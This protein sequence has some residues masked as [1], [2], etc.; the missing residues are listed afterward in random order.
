[1]IDH[2]MRNFALFFIAILISPKLFCQM[3]EV[4]KSEILDYVRANPKVLKV[5]K[6]ETGVGVEDDKG[7]TIIPS[8]FY[9]VSI[10]SATSKFKEPKFLVS[11]KCEKDFNI[12]SLDNTPIFSSDQYAIVQAAPGYLIVTPPAKDTSFIL[13]YHGD[14]IDHL[15]K[16]MIQ[17]VIVPK[18][19][20]KNKGYYVLGKNRNGGYHLALISDELEFIKPLSDHVIKV[21]EHGIIV[22]NNSGN[23]GTLYDLNMKEI[24]SSEIAIPKYVFE[25]TFIYSNQTNYTSGIMNFKGDTL[26]TSELMR[27][28][29]KDVRQDVIKYTTHF[30]YK[31]GAVSSEGKEI[32]PAGDAYISWITSEG[33]L[34]LQYFDKKK[35]EKTIYDLTKR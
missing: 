6:K 21:Q 19:S 33:N 16:W 18:Y 28:S 15:E 22:R 26:F 14:S 9:R 35:K 12:L 5:V 3:Q 30:S 8:V 1:M 34:Y 27:F 2:T 17:P 20:S 29:D 13:D 32:I 24:W 7:R 25:K 11:K 4:K 31:S 10:L 23:G